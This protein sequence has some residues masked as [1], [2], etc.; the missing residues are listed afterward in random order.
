MCM[1]IIKFNNRK[2]KKAFNKKKKKRKKHR[3]IK[4]TDLSG[5]WVPFQFL[6]KKLNNKHN[7]ILVYLSYVKW[8]IFFLK[9]YG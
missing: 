7:Y 9:D 5:P 1:Y 3:K 6:F 8:L 4:K 2:I